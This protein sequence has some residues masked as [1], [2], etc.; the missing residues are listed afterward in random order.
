MKREAR[1]QSNLLKMRAAMS[2][3]CNHRAEEDAVREATKVSDMRQ[4]K[5]NAKAPF[6]E[7]VKQ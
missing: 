4:A 6:A 7:K 2:E 5:E 1:R 3:Q